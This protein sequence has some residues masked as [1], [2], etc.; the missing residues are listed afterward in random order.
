M[1]S[2]Y[3]DQ[4]LSDLNVRAAHI[5]DIIISLLVAR[6]PYIYVYLEF[7]SPTCRTYHCLLTKNHRSDNVLLHLNSF[8]KFGFAGPAM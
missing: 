3:L 7:R 5:L 4:G 1:I 6:V 2:Y 8:F